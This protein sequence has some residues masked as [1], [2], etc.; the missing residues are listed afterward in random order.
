MAV[1]W[2]GLRRAG[3]ARDDAVVVAASDR[4]FM[5]ATHCVTN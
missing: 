5:T 4:S 3:G 2:Q 1:E